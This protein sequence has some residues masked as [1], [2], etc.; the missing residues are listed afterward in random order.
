MR[1]LHSIGQTVDFELNRRS[2]VKGGISL[3]AAASL[4]GCGSSDNGDV[5]YVGSDNK[6]NTPIS[7]DIYYTKDPVYRYGTSAHNCGGRCII[8]AQVVD[9]SRIVRFL[10]DET[11]YAFDGT[12]LDEANR[13]T[14]QS[15]ACARCRA[16]KGRLYHPGRLKYPLKQTKQ[17][18]DMSGFE[19]I[20]WQQALKEISDRRKAVQ[21]A[22]GIESVHNIYACGNVGSSFQG[23]SYGVFYA[24]SPAD[25][26]LGGSAGAISDYSFHQA[27]YMGSYGMGSYS[28]RIN[29]SPT[30][31]DIAGTGK[32]I[33][34]W[35]A[36]IPSTHNPFA[37]P[38]IKGVED[39]KKRDPDAK[40][41][42][43]GPELSECGIAFADEW[44]QTR[45]YTDV[46][47]VMAMIHEML[48]NTFSSTGAILTDASK[49]QPWLDVNYLDTMVYG[50]FDSPGYWLNL[51]DGTFDMLTAAPANADPKSKVISGDPH[52]WVS[53]VPDG[54]SLSAYVLGAT[55]NRLVSAQYGSGNYVAKSFTAKVPSITRNKS[56]C[57]YTAPSNTKFEYKKHFAVPKTPE[58]ASAITGISADRIREL[59]KMYIMAAKNGQPIW[60]EWAG[61]QLKQAEGCTTL[62]ALEVLNIVAKNWGITGTGINNAALSNA[63]GRTCTNDPNQITAASVM[64]A[65]WASPSLPKNRLHPQ[66]SCTAWHNAIKFAFG[67][68]LKQNGYKP[69]IPGWSGLGTGKAYHSDGG[70]KS[71]IR[72]KDVSY[73]STPDALE[74]ATYTETGTDGIT[75]T[76]YDYDGRSSNAPVYSGY[77]F[78]LNASGNIP[79]NQHANSIDS[80]EMYKY[81]PTYSVDYKNA[82]NPSFNTSTM[83][84][85]FYM[86]CFDNFMS[87]SARYADYVL[88]A[89]T[90]W[91]QEDFISLQTGD[92]LYI[93]S[94]IPGPGESLATWDFAREWIKTN[95]GPDDAA[96]FTGMGADTTFKQVFQKYYNTNV[97]TDSNSPFYNKSWEEFLKQPLS[98]GTPSIATTQKLTTS[99]LRENLDDYLNGVSGDITTTPFFADIIT[100]DATAASGV[101]GFCIDQF[102][103]TVT[104]PNQSKR[105]HVYSDSLAWRYKNLYSK[106]HGYL[107]LSEQGQYKDDG[108]GDPVVQPLPMYYDYHDYFIEAYNLN[109]KTEL[110]G[111]YLL[112]TTHDRFR[113]HSSFSETPLLRELTHRVQNGDLYSGNDH[114]YYAVSSDPDTDFNTFYP[115]NAKIG[116]NG[117]PTD[118]EIASYADLWVN[119]DDFTGMPDGTLVK[120]ENE[121]GAVYCTIRKTERCVRGY[122]GLHQGCWFDPR[123]I[124]G[125]IVDVGGNCNTLMSSKP[126]RIDH[127]NAQQSAMVKI[128]KVEG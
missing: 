121:V 21:N 89:K 20:T 49:G 4:Y 64:P 41:I 51:N 119:S 58:W 109:S 99:T 14:T 3:G 112:T 93:D 33:V 81:L 2:F 70:T 91:E 79:I 56:T 74:P 63:I 29:M 54:R 83:S 104:A 94:V 92:N 65:T 126:S 11:K 124:N 60:N 59:A 85:A 123:T 47:L 75:R 110:Q 76:Y 113:A 25:K 6:D 36:N 46:A 128:T 100:I 88:P 50:F 43:V 19:R 103:E 10:T 18:G 24:P 1:K 80:S 111:R 57:S 68:K 114:G 35:G 96:T 45:P 42:F 55:D 23:G 97:K 82:V 8:K 120:V 27:S 44:I 77:R 5:V 38:W 13:N 30:S 12:Y 98:H 61:G 62:F 37:Y 28:G 107:S 101:Y 95:S 118:K 67:D 78:I 9:N 72:R 84:E 116:E 22:Y 122:V 40:V 66:P 53:P 90:T 125:K 108:E 115:L 102:A 39:M 117:L 52:I 15:R 17:R 105:F 34:L 86:V 26:L 106:W 48:I 71:L 31:D 127:G 16:Y 7:D 87:P 69:N 32:Y 73:I